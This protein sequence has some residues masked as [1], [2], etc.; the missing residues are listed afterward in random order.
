M[1]TIVEVSVIEDNAWRRLVTDWWELSTSSIAAGCYTASYYQFGAG[2]RFQSVNVPQG[3][4]IDLA[5]I[6]F[7]ARAGWSGA[8]C[9]TRI[10]AEDVDDAAAFADDKDAFDARW[11]ARTT[12]KVDWDNIPA[13]TQD[14][15]GP[16]TKS[17]E[18]KTVI[19]EIVDR[20]GWAANNDIVIFWEDFED[21]S[22]RASYN[23]RD[24]YNYG[25]GTAPLLHIEYTA[26]IPRHGFVMFQ[27][28]AIV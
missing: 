12:A 26:T 16:D 19:Q 15:S 7:K 2:M 28:P 10:S 21:R 20:A 11:A 13:W 17:P 3:A 23:F 18:I 5:Y 14:E 27:D 1:S 6:Q 24:A 25:E 4:T 8:N 22:T 9:R